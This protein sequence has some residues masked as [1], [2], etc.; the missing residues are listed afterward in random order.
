[1]VEIS[2][3][4]LSDFVERFVRWNFVSSY[5]IVESFWSEIVENKMNLNPVKIITK[6]F[7]NSKYLQMKP[8]SRVP[9]TLHRGLVNPIK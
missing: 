8:A 1:M 3:D 2:L 5:K 9:G 7:N 4:N 6:H